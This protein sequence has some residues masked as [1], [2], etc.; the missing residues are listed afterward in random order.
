MAQIEFDPIGGPWAVVAI[1]IGLLLLLAIG[2]RRSE[3]NFRQ[4]CVL[5]TLRI[6][7]ILVL[8]VAMT[9]PA[10]VITRTE[11]QP[12]TLGIIADESLSMQVTDMLAG[13]SRWDALRRRMQEAAAALETL[14]QYLNVTIYT[15][16]EQLKSVETSQGVAQLPEE[17]SG[18]QSALGASLAEFLQRHRGERL[19]GVIVL[20]DGAQRAYPPLD[21]PPRTA[22]K[23]AA[24]QGCPIYA[25]TFGQARSEGQASDVAITQMIAGPTVY[26]NNVLAVDT[27]IHAVG[28]ANREVVLQLLFETEAG[29]LEPV[30]T[31]RLLVQQDDERLSA[32]LEYVPP[33]P[34][35][36]KVLLR[37]ELQA[38]EIVTSNNQMGTFVT[39]LPG[40]VRLLFL[41]GNP[42]RKER[43]AI[44]SAL[45]A[46]PDIRVDT[47]WCNMFRASRP[48]ATAAEMDWERY[49]VFL[50]GDFH[51]T[52]LPA[53][54]WQQV[55]DQVAAGSGLIM[56]GGDYSFGAGGFAETPLA[57]V[58][59]VEM[60][61]LEQQQIGDPPSRDL[62]L[63]VGN[64][65]LQMLPTTS[66]VRGIGHP[67]L[68]L[69][70]RPGENLA[71]WRQLPRLSGANRLGAL[72]P[73]AT[74]LAESSP[75]NAP[76][77]VAQGHGS[78][79]VLALAV[80]STH[81]WI[82]NGDP[83]QEFS[84]ELRRFWR[85]LALWLAKQE[86]QD[87]GRIQIQL[88]RRRFGIGQH[89]P[90]TAIAEPTLELPTA[91]ELIATLRPPEGDPVDLTLQ[92]SNNV[93]KGRTE[94]LTLPGDY[95]L[96][97]APRDATS[98]W[99]PARARFT[100]HQEDLE[101][102]NPM[103]DPAL[104]ASLAR[105]TASVGGLAGRPET[106]P[107]LLRRLASDPP[108][109][110]IERSHKQTYWDRWWVLLAFVALLGAEW[111]LRKRWGLV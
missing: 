54:I 108:N 41:S 71:L 98:G 25:F 81:R 36:F 53:T 38:D 9:R 107:N 8:A 65:G 85:Q 23:Q 20:S 18:Q 105:Q 79:R 47:L 19:A 1:V 91:P 46:S 3:T 33:S 27:E 80:D 2:P 86:D 88:E 37:A 82:F 67:M 73:R 97:V 101:L 92:M 106:L 45:A 14:E 44:R 96:E 60:S 7:A 26:Q 55:A 90:F 62:H 102:E 109:V 83:D 34:G 95:V 76:L 28:A 12:A 11:T 51:S 35:E 59:P 104:L 5:T 16:G 103:A 43:G 93:S 68:Q 74:I 21:L 66:D 72:K 57:D 17:P 48:L 52:L 32:R 111:F 56:I 100:V 4:R 70:E 61:R 63:E 84:L 69:A 42:L 31:T 6:I 10:R 15:F 64:D 39:V 13:E 94:A 50:I 77:L 78:G 40:G 75:G 99:E 58:L 89:A 29:A 30:A 87:A 24:D 49:D 22:A 110:R